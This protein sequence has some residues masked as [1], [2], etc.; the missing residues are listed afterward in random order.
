MPPSG[1][2][3]SYPPGTCLPVMLTRGAFRDVKSDDLRGYA[4]CHFFAGLGGWPY[5]LRLEPAGP[6]TDL[7]GQVLARA[8]RSASS[9]KG[10]A[11]QMSATSGQ[12]GV[13]LSRSESLA[14]SL[15]NRLM[16]V[17][18]E[19]G[20]TLYGLTWKVLATPSHR[21]FFLLRA[22]EHRTAGTAYSSWVTPSTQGLEGHAGD[23]DGFPRIRM[24]ACAG[25]STSYRGKRGWWCLGG[26][27][28]G[29]L[30]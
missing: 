15:V 22:S 8:S 9:G 2:G 20:S 25:A 21:R 29:A 5:A 3:T 6:T 7:F 1:C 28:L 27:S 4:Q 23:V 12:S 26:G 10:P 17:T 13:A 16:G 19:H 18:A 30:Q 24:A 14:L 11:S